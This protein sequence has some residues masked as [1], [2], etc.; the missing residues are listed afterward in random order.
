MEVIVR[1]FAL[2][3][4][5]LAFSQYLHRLYIYAVV[6][7]CVLLILQFQNTPLWLTIVF[8]GTFIMLIGLGL[9]LIFIGKFTMFEKE[10]EDGTHN[11]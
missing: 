2:F 8:S 1:G 4:D 10:G 7:L 11:D 5:I 6:T 9:L 3:L